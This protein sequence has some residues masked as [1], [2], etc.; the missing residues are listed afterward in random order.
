MQP[1]VCT[2]VYVSICIQKFN[3]IVLKMKEKVLVVK[4]L[5]QR[6]W[7][8]KILTLPDCP[9]KKAAPIYSPTMTV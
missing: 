4:L 3:K 7:A 8:F 5:G 6:T 9:P 2:Y 1:H